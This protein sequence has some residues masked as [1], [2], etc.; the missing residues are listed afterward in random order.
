M[1][2]IVLTA[3]L[4]A[5]AGQ[6][7]V[8]CGSLLGDGPTRDDSGQVVEAGELEAFDLQV[9]DC[10]NDPGADAV[11]TVMAVPCTELHDFE[12]YHS[13]D[14]ADGDYPGADTIQSQWTQGC[15]AE[16]EGFVGTSFDQSLLDISGIFPT[17][18][19]WNELGDREV[20]CSVTAVDGNPREG[21]ARNTRI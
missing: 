10:F 1:G 19:T 11:D 21:S 20:L 12:V 2:R 8:G 4:W 7:L 16:F 9:G 15:L 6:V 5:L 18:E 3:S 14:L 17:E 13:F